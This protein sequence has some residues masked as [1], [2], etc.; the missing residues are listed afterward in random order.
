V[1]TGPFDH[2]D[3]AYWMTHDGALKAAVDA[4]LKARLDAGD[5]QKALAG[6][7]GLP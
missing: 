1:V 4:V 2:F 6:A 3:K 7:A 5:Y